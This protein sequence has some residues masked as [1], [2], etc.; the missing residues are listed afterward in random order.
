MHQAD[1][2]RLSRT[3][4]RSPVRCDAALWPWG[5]SE[6]A[7]GCPGRVGGMHNRPA[8]L[9]GPGQSGGD[10]LEAT[11]NKTR[12]GRPDGTIAT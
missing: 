11:T 5:V 7:E 6:Y 4:E 1:Q 9:L 10:R 12:L 2:A 8:E 3:A